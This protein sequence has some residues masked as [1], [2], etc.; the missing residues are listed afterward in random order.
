[1]IPTRSNGLCICRGQRTRKNSRRRSAATRTAIS[2]SWTPAESMNSSRLRSIVA[3]WASPERLAGV[4][5]RSRGGEH[6]SP[7]PAAALNERQQEQAITRTGAP[8][9]NPIA[10]RRR[11]DPGRGHAP[12]RRRS[13][14]PSC[15]CRSWG[16][17]VDV[18]WNRR[19]TRN[20]TSCT[21][22]CLPIR[23]CQ[24]VQDQSWLL[25]H[26]IVLL[27]IQGHGGVPALS[28]RADGGLRR[29][30]LHRAIQS[31][32]AER[33]LPRGRASTLVAD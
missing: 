21:D 27:L 33:A 18:A 11:I 13:A 9:R 14:L 26:R 3:I 31:R 15:H 4:R 8:L 23:H 12:S 1:V 25:R 24:P 2:A 10:P 20:R 32:P 6:S 5:K 29:T 19:L 22:R 16:T 17:A 28:S 7:F 30:P